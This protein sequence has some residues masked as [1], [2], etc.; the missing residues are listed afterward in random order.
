MS[1]DTDSISSINT[2]RYESI[3]NE[4]ITIGKAE[5]VKPVKA[6][7]QGKIEVDMSMFFTPPEIAEARRAEEAKRRNQCLR[8]E[9]F[10][11]V[12]DNCTSQECHQHE[13]ELEGCYLDFC[14]HA[15]ILQ[16]SLRSLV[17]LS[18]ES[19]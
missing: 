4:P 6:E 2:L 9:M 5:S 14:P 18:S 13:P 12:C 16:G 11:E 8:Q 19:R 7:P 10:W 17:T 3:W 15:S 1:S